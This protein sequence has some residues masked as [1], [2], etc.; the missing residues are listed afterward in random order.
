MG[1][2][3]TSVPDGGCPPHPVPFFKMYNITFNFSHA[4]THTCFYFHIFAYTGS[5]YN[6]PMHK[7]CLRIC[8]FCFW[9]KHNILAVHVNLQMLWAGFRWGAEPSIS[10]LFCRIANVLHFL[11]VCGQLLYQLGA[12]PPSCSFF[13]MHN[14]FFTISHLIS[15]MH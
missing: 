9:D 1:L 13:K 11:L 14:Q 15:F 7:T 4:L 10:R 12:A 6:V 3:T 2:W 8:I 5:D